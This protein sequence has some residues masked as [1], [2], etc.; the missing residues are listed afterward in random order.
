LRCNC[1]ASWVLAFCRSR[2]NPL[3][4]NGIPPAPVSAVEMT[5]IG[6][7]YKAAEG[8]TGTS[9]R[10]A[11]LPTHWNDGMNLVGRDG[12]GESVWLAWFLVENLQLFTR[13]PILMTARPWAPPPA[14]NARSIRS[15]RAG[16]SSRAAATPCT[17]ARHG[18]G[19]PAPGK[20]RGAADPAARP[21]VE[22]VGPGTR[23]SQGLRA[24]RPRKRRP[25]YP[26][27]DLNDDGVRHD[28]RP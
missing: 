11:H 3:T 10:P 26:C 5:G 27:R 9:E 24:R 12:R 8:L 7:E 18:S 4:P 13:A 23:L 14:R 6:Q 17:I 1:R 2:I 15:A 22:Q 25:I 16:R 21:A 19:R 20:A 28:G